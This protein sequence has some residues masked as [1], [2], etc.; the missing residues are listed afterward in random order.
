[1]TICC[2]G[3]LVLDVIVRLEQPLAPTPTRPRRSCSAP[4]ARARTSPRGWP[5]SAARSRFVGK[6]ARRRRRATL[7][8]AASAG[9]RRR[10]RRPGRARRQRH[11][12]SPSCSRPASG[13][14]ARTAASRPSSGQT[15]STR[16]G[17][18]TAATSTSRATRSCASRSA[19]RPPRASAH[20]R[21]AGRRVSVDLSSWSAIRDYGA[22]RF[23]ADLEGSR[24]TSC[25][26]TRT[27]TRSSAA[28][29]RAAP[30]SSSAGAAGASF[31]GFERAA[32]RR[33]SVDSTGAGDA[34][35]AGWLV[36]GPDL[37]LEAAARC[38]AQAGS[39]PHAVA[40]LARMRHLIQVSDEVRTALEDERAVVALETTLVAHGFPAPD[41]VETG[42]ASEAAVRAAGAIPA[43][44]G[45]LDGRIRIGLDQRGAR[46]VH[47]RRAQARPARPRRLRGSGRGRRDNGRRHAHRSGRRRDPVHGHRRP[48]RRP[49]RLPD[50]AGRL[51]RPRAPSRASRPSSPRPGVKSILDVPATVELLETLGIPVIGYRTDTLPLFYDAAG[52]PPVSARSDEVGRDR[53]DRRR[54]L[55]SR[56]QRHSSS[57]ARRPRAST[58][59]PL[60]EEA[61]RRRHA[62]GRQRASP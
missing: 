4:V 42:L 23:R 45:V 51:G 44:I 25:S 16:H 7:A 22:V 5:R 3:D 19:S 59:T 58:S 52:G 30:G 38:V 31:D 48:R 55:A 50:S 43:T 34:F 53:P 57:V 20:A 9:A 14:C 6:R 49:P 10:A 40:R 2:L 32:L 24:P 18:R 56:R 11:R 1:M 54:P 36:G 39:M 60:I 29:S 15:R 35:A 46:A 12:S 28:A 62:R 41:G 27:R 8:A 17:S 21:S 33:S 37:A 26:R 47:A 61:A 13:R